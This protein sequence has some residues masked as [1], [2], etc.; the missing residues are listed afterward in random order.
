MNYYLKERNGRIASEQQELFR[1][2]IAIPEA[3]EDKVFAAYVANRKENTAVIPTAPTFQT[4]TARGLLTAVAILLMGLLTIRK[5]VP[6]VFASINERF[7]PWA[8]T[9]GTMANVNLQDESFSEFLAVFR[10]SVP[11]DTTTPVANAAS[12]P[13]KASPSEAASEPVSARDPLQEF[14][15]AAPDQIAGLRKIF[16]EISRA[17]DD[18]ARQQILLEFQQ[19]VTAL[20]DS[21]RMTG[22]RPFWLLACALEGLLK[23]LCKNAADVTPS[24]LGTAAGAVDLLEV[25][26]VPGLNP[27]LATEPP[28]KLLAVDDDPVS[29]LAISFALKK[30]FNPPDL[31]PD[32]ET[33]LGLIERQAYDAI[34]LDVDMPGMDGYELCMKVHQNDG[35]QTTPV[36]FVTRHG[37]FQS[38][39]KSTLS[40]GQDLIAKPF[41]AFEIT[42]KALTLALRG[43]LQ[44]AAAGRA[45]RASNPAIAGAT[46]EPAAM[47]ASDA[48]MPM[49]PVTDKP[50]W[51]VT[52]RGFQ[53]LFGGSRDDSPDSFLT[54]APAYLEQ[55]RAHLLAAQHAANPAELQKFL[56]QLY[57]G[58]NALSS[59]AERAE[60][61]T[62]SRLSSSLEGMLKKLLD[63][64]NLCTPSTFTAAA[65]A[66]ELLEELCRHPGGSPDLV[67][68]PVR[69][70]VVDDDPVARR[71]ISMA[72]QLVFGR[73]ENAESGEAAVAIA[74]EKPLDLILLD[75]LMPGMDGFVACQRIHETG[76]NARTPVLFITSQDDM[77]ARA[78]AADAGGCGFIPKPVLSSQITL[79]ALTFI[80]RARLNKS[81]SQQVFEG[82]A[83]LQPA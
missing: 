34:F 72:V 7:N 39:A 66:L 57:V 27:D 74:K 23:Q 55:L 68:P 11:P 62:I 51:E 41:L 48:A 69:I 49:P 56:G 67:N 36:V 17:V 50:S 76:Q 79:V 65:S 81:L 28:V 52:D 14:F 31:A 40:G 5:L 83:S 16:S 46:S 13:G 63:R 12:E 45:S 15:T 20:K 9:A 60:L 26:A 64:T 6:E 10:A 3:V 21:A 33:A 78:K 32:G 44:K 38:R 35:H 25:L 59:E 82:A 47:P 61:R 53:A 73:P 54:H 1:K 4:M 58:V 42:V 70:L 30:A 37:D 80:M 43:R 19:Q 71:A 29:R 8:Q 18:N 22:L 24:A 77:E 75:V 2:R